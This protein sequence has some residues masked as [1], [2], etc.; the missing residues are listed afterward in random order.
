MDKLK[1]RVPKIE[2]SAGFAR[3]WA[4]GD[5][6]I[7]H[8][9]NA[10]SFLFPQGE[11]FFIDAARMVVRDSAQTLDP[12]LAQAVQGFVAQE[13]LHRFQHVQYNTVLLA[14]GYENT[15]EKFIA[16]LQAWSLRNFSP[17]SN[18]AL[19]CGY[20]HYTAIL[21]DFVL[22]HPTL[23]NSWAP[24]LALVW[25][26][27]AVEET[28][29]KAVCFDLYRAAGGGTMRRWLTFVFVSFTFSYIFGRLYINMLYRD[30]C[31]RPRRITTTLKQIMRFY[32]GKSGAAWYL[33]KY[34]VRY[35]KPGFHPWQHDIR[36]Q[37]QQWLRLNAVSLREL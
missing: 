8:T 37:L 10:L 7:T 28:E 32:F 25:G 2:W 35:F 29:H 4:A 30:G 5:P 27:H 14:Q 6:A 3:H 24:E 16:A 22:S 20:E 15:V 11:Q 9:F 21:G 17:L 26:W 33:V 19:V 31:W 23:L 12:N 13:S 36:N 18:L 34:G 1:T